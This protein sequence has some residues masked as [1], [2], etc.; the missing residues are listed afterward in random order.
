[1][2]AT[3]GG[4]H[5]N[6]NHLGRLSMTPDPMVST[7]DRKPDFYAVIRDNS[8]YTDQDGGRPFAVTLAHECDGY[9]WHGNGNRYRS[10][11]LWLLYPTVDPLAPPA[12]IT[13]SWDEAEPSDEECEAEYQA[14]L[15]SAEWFSPMAD[16]GD[17]PFAFIN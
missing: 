12:P 13:L 11:D 15:S 10:S 16:Q 5:E 17:L 14:S 6:T 9:I 3:G 1:M 8:K 7:M 4:E 2:A